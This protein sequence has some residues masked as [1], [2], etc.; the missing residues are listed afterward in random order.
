M[1]EFRCKNCNQWVELIQ[2]RAGLFGK[3]K[4]R[5]IRTLINFLSGVGG[6]KGSKHDC[7]EKYNKPFPC[8]D[9]SQEIYISKEKHES[10]RNK[11]L[12]FRTD[13]KKGGLKDKDHICKKRLFSR[14]H[15]IT[16][17]VYN[18]QRYCSVCGTN[19]METVFMNCPACWALECRDCGH[20]MLPKAEP[21]GLK[22][23]KMKRSYYDKED[24]LI[25]YIETIR[26]YP[27]DK[28]GSMKT[29]DYARWIKK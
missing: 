17:V 24:K 22:L 1:A 27:C 28:C 4:I 13:E 19:W 16:K 18:P 23:S 9:C 11:I 20:Q 29:K 3:S 21:I 10:G 6:K 15:R 8:Q 12:N 26:E 2:Q 25:E 5:D 14:F 7:P